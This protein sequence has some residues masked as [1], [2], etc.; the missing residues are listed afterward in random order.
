MIVTRHA[1][2]ELPCHRQAG[3]RS[4]AHVAANRAGWVAA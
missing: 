1:N 2:P 3:A 4:A